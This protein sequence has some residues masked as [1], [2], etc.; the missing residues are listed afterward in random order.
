M[1]VVDFQP[2]GVE[3]A[4]AI[5]ATEGVR[6][7]LMQSGA[8]DVVSGGDVADGV[9]AAEESDLRAA[10]AH[11]DEARRLIAM[12]AWSD[13]A[14]AARAAIVE[15]RA[16]YAQIGRREELADATYLLGVASLELGADDA[17]DAAFGALAALYPGYADARAP[18]ASP[19]ARA[20]MRA[21]DAEAV[22]TRIPRAEVAYVRD[23]VHA[24]WVV[25]GTVERTGEVVARIWG[26][27]AEAGDARLVAEVHG[28]FV[29]VPAPERSDAYERVARGIEAA[30]VARGP[31]TPRPVEPAAPE[32]EPAV[33]PEGR[34]RAWMWAGAA[35][36]LGAGGLVAWA[37]WEPAPLPVQGGDTWSIKIDGL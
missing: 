22:P 21:A 5:T 27:A 37:I 10:R 23:A 17:A 2:V 26:P 28:N 9:S 25:T 30:A 24:D 1:A 11:V 16:A 29:P 33:A 20:R 31:V 8:L 18:Q 34:K 3:Y 13:A 15:H 6:A 35:A 12:G 7:A 19:V 32:S 4:D 14:E 36:V